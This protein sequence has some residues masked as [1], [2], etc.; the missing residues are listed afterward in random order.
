[1][2]AIVMWQDAQRLIAVVVGPL[3]RAETAMIPMT[4]LRDSALVFGRAHVQTASYP[5]AIA[6]ANWPRREECAG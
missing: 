5:V 6:P 2:R 3:D 1:M 4:G